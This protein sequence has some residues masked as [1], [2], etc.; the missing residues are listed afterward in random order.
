ML[1]KKSFLFS[2]M[3]QTAGL[4]FAVRKWVERVPR[5]FTESEHNSQKNKTK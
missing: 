3:T 2:K 5:N 4:G 1:I